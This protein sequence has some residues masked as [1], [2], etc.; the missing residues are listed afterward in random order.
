MHNAH[1]GFAPNTSRSIVTSDSKAT[2]LTV[3]ITR[4]GFTQIAVSITQKSYSTYRTHYSKSY[5]TYRILYALARYAT[6]RSRDIARL[7]VVEI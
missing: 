2:Q 3:S 4:K 7:T 1:L 5:S 6:G